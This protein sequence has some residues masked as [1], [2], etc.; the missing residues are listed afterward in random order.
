MIEKTRIFFKEGKQ[1]SPLLVQLKEDAKTAEDGKAVKDLANYELSYSEAAG[2]CATFA[3]RLVWVPRAI[4]RLEPKIA[5][6]VVNQR[7]L[8]L[9]EPYSP[10]LGF[11]R[12]EGNFD[13][14]RATVDMG[15]GRKSPEVTIEMTIRL[16]KLNELPLN[17]FYTAIRSRQLQPTDWYQEIP[18]Q[19]RLNP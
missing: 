17:D 11:Y 6:V 1:P 9:I 12:G 15:S 3:E 4:E 10:L 14:S 16:N 2:F 5:K 19:Y 18:R 13:G 7:G 8:P